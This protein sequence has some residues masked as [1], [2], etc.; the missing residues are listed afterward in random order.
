MKRKRIYPKRPRKPG[1]TWG[2]LA[3]RVL[4]AIAELGPMTRAELCQHLSH[5][6]ASLSSV[7]ARLRKETPLR[8]QR[9]YVSGWVYDHEG[10]REY[11]RAQFSLGAEPDKPLRRR[12]TK[13]EIHSSLQATYHTRMKTASVFNLGM[14]RNQLTQRAKQIRSSHDSGTDQH[15]A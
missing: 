8:A 14:T 1:S 10:M 7:I 2:V 5:D 12:M 4:T 11:P 9:L 13:R 6:A 15:L 3:E